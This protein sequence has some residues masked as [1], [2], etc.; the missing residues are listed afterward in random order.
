MGLSPHIPRVFLSLCNR[1]GS[2][3]SVPDSR[4]SSWSPWETFWN[5]S[6]QQL[7]SSEF[8]AAKGFQLLRQLP[9][10]DTK[11]FDEGQ[12]LI[13]FPFNGIYGTLKGAQREN[14]VCKRRMDAAFTQTSFISWDTKECVNS[15]GSMSSQ[16][17]R[18]ITCSFNKITQLLLFS[19]I[20]CN[21][22]K[23]GGIKQVNLLQLYSDVY[24][25]QFSNMFL[26]S[27]LAS[28]STNYWTHFSHATT[29]I[30]WTNARANTFLTLN[31]TAV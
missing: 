27:S 17:F 11:I 16:K 28:Y 3:R 6:L 4:G 20:Q 21:S 1:D 13:K 12:S 25:R 23:F 24:Q 31:M 29:S 14:V 22:L 7:V 2:H 19:F 15:K 26:A 30:R 5:H 18:Y 10:A 8:T 9:V